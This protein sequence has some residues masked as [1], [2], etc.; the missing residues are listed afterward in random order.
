MNPENNEN[1]S[2]HDAVRVQARPSPYDKGMSFVEFV[3]RSRPDRL[4]EPEPP[5]PPSLEVLATNY[6]QA[7]ERFEQAADTF[8]N[9]HA[10][11]RAA[12]AAESEARAAL[13][14]AKDEYA[15]VVETGDV[16]TEAV[17]KRKLQKAVQTHT[18]AAT[19]VAVMAGAKEPQ[20]LDYDSVTGPLQPL[21]VRI[22]EVEAATIPAEIGTFL[23]ALHACAK[24]KSWVPSW[25]DFLAGVF[26]ED[27]AR[28]LELRDQLLAKYGISIHP[29]ESPDA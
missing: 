21:V 28:Q 13:D 18:E 17:A 20:Q 4:P 11:R 22:G 9:W 2:L 7:K 26:K 29:G 15:R 12:A 8:T 3:N 5:Q 16:P 27:A 24:L 6:R 1:F 23:N 19:V 25:G 14:V 10:R